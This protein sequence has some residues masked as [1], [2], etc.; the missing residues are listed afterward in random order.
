MPLRIAVFGQ[1]QFG[2]D[3]LARLIEAGHEIVGVYTPP[4]GAR[5]DPLA[6][7]ASERGLRLLRQTPFLRRLGLVT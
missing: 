6:A 4:E 3:V 5:P 2:C 7:L 1:A